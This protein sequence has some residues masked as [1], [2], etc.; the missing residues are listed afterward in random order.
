MS[1]VSRSHPLRDIAVPFVAAAP[2]ERGSARGCGRPRKT[3]R[4]SGLSAF[5]G[6]HWP[7]AT[8]QHGARE[9]RLGE[10][11]K[12]E[13]RAV[14]KWALTGRIVGALGGSYHSHTARTPGSWPTATSAR[15]R[16]A[17]GSASGPLPPV[18][19]SPAGTGGVGSAIREPGRTARQ[20]DPT[21]DPAGT[22]RPGR[23][24]HSRRP[25]TS[26]PRRAAPPRTRANLAAAG[27]TERQWQARWEASRI[28]LTADGEA[29]KPWGNETI[30]W[31]PDEGWLELKLPPPLASLANRPHGRYRL[32]CRVAFGYRA[33]AVAAQTA[34]AWSLRHHTQPRVRALVPGRELDVPRCPR[35]VPR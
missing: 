33:D 1:T 15:S 20:V 28:F 19:P 27:L 6:G 25:G 35:P 8:S 3:R 16:P 4:Y 30:R 12:A 23:R 32:S 31:H 5:T 21:E 9:G 2:V 22:P 11:G 13:S 24:V 34:S 29:A 18:S 17:C 7:A 26:D 10:K 14:R